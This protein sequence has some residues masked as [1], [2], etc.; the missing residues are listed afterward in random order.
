[1]RNQFQQFERDISLDFIRIT[2]TLLVICLH[3]SANG[4]YFL[5]KN[6]W[7][8]ANVYESVSRTAVPLFFMVTGALL[9]PREISLQSILMRLWRVVIPLVVWSAL[10]LIYQQVNFYAW[11]PKILK[12]PVIYHLWYLY[13]LIG[14]YLFLP[15][16]AGFFQANN[17]KTLLFVMAV[18]F[19]GATIVPT[20][21]AIAYAPAEYNGISWEFLS[22]Y[23]GYMVLGAILYREITFKKPL[24]IISVLI[25][26]GCTAAIACLTWFRSIHVGHPDDTFYA[27]GSPFVALGAAAAFVFL[28]EFSRNYLLKSKW[29][30]AVSSRLSR[31]CFGVYLVHAMI[32]DI[33]Y[34]KSF[35]Y[36]FTNPWVAIPIVTLAAF[37]VSAAIVGVLQKLPLI[38]RIVPA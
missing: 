17:L 7:W 8:A 36:N 14:A 24:L 27:Y 19:F 11:I 35:H 32:L 18:W 28:R 12:A 4:F 22:L 10:Y 15:V 37:G 21:W 31:L 13:T 16:T 23:A 5:N 25:W 34:L 26:G 1:M 9:L 30:L 38:R 20:I 33:F 6:H 2:S 3:V 29:V